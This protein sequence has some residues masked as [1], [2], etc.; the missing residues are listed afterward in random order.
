MSEYALVARKGLILIATGVVLTVG[1]VFAW[2]SS[3]AGPQVREFRRPPSFAEVESETSHLEGV[4]N[5][6]A[7]DVGDPTGRVAEHGGYRLVPLGFEGELPVTDSQTSPGR[8]TVTDD[9]KILRQSPLFVD[10]SPLI[11]NLDRVLIDTFDGDSNTVIRQR[12]VDLA[13]KN[14]YIEIVRV[15]RLTQPIDILV[16][17][18]SASLQLDTLDIKG[19]PAVMLHPTANRPVPRPFVQLRLFDGRVETSFTA[20][21]FQPD[22][23][24]S[25]AASTVTEAYDE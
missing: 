14:R 13:D 18:A 8:G 15:L 11:P 17:G 9:E 5:I 1:S 3:T 23:V 4:R 24:L 2:R 22:E 20:D 6:G 10:F 7:E 25:L 21:G 12:F 19:I 16:P